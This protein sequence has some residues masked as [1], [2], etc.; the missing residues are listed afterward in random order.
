[1]YRVFENLSNFAAYL[2]QLGNDFSP[3]AGARSAPAADRPGSARDARQLGQELQVFAQRVQQPRA[4]LQE[5]LE[6]VHAVCVGWTSGPGDP[7]GCEG[8]LHRLREEVS[9]IEQELTGVRLDAPADDEGML[10]G[11][12]EV[13]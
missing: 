2:D 12:S 8:D 4:D 6:L 9:R 13:R 11:S 10:E 7:G 3:A 5:R 1:M